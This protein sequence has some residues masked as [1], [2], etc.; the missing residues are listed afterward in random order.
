MLLQTK[1]QNGIEIL[2]TISMIGKERL[3]IFG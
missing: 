3:V 2:Q 1:I